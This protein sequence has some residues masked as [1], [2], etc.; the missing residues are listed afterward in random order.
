MWFQP[1]TDDTA[2]EP[3]TRRCFCEIPTGT[4]RSGLMQSSAPFGPSSGS[5]RGGH[6]WSWRDVLR[7]QRSRRTATTAGVKL[8]QLGCVGREPRERD[9]ALLLSSVCEHSCSCRFLPSLFISERLKAQNLLSLQHPWLCVWAPS[10]CTEKS[11]P[12]H[13][14]SPANDSSVWS[15]PPLADWVGLSSHIPKGLKDPVEGL[16]RCVGSGL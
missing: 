12:G 7:V 8:H 6:R 13:L 4:R 2:A 10:S 1:L 16:Q 3:D 11:Q 15:S 9:A 5:A 14:L